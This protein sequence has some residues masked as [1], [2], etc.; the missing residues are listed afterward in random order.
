[1]NII[2]GDNYGVTLPCGNVLGS[3]GENML[4]THRVYHPRFE[5]ASYILRLRYRDNVIYDTEIVGGILTVYGSLLRFAGEVEAQFRAVKTDE[6]ELRLVFQSEI[7]KLRIEPSISG[8]SS[9]IPPYEE[10]LTM[11]EEL[12]DLMRRIGTKSV[13]RVTLGAGVRFGRCTDAHSEDAPI[14]S[15]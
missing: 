8:S 7:F 11:F 5:N 2:I 12:L 13:T 15:V 3:V 9:E 1:M 4:R 14:P 6:D 10:S